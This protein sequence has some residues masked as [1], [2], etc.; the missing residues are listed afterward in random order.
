MSL[1]PLN[2][3]AIQEGFRLVSKANPRSS[4]HGCLLAS[5][6]LPK[7]FRS[8]LATVLLQSPVVPPIMQS[9]H[10]KFRTSPPPPF[11]SLRYQRKESQ[12]S[13]LLYPSR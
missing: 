8:T 4:L 5:G 10:R 6:A 3:R 1:F 13:L 9:P 12:Q 7:G 11:L 2:K